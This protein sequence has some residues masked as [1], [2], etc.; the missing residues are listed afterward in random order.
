[1]QQLILLTQ[2]RQKKPVILGVKQNA[3]DLTK[4]GHIIALLEID[5]QNNKVYVSNPG[6]EDDSEKHGWLDFDLV[7]DAARSKFAALIQATPQ[8]INTFETVH[9]TAASKWYKWNGRLYCVPKAA[10]GSTDLLSYALSK[11]GPQ[12]PNECLHYAMK[13]ASAMFS[14]SVAKSSGSKRCATPIKQ[15]LLYVAAKELM[16]GKPSVVR[17]RG[18]RTGTKKDGTKLWSRHY[19]T[20][21]GVYKNANMANLKETDFIILDPG[22]AY[23]TQ[24]GKGNHILLRKEED[25]YHYRNPKGMN[26]YQI[27][28]YSAPSKY[29]SYIAYDD[30]S[31]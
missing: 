5:E 12:K 28:I 7:C 20:I 17:V 22:G 26:G 16:D 14:M 15:N 13:Y 6:A 3:L 11:V 29:A 9:I 25:L 23:K 10:N 30:P 19:V 18:G 1:M 2:L 8:A 21:V 27:Y 24:L 4:G 31:K